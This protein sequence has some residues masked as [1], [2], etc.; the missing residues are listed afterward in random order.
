MI[1]TVQ[2]TDDML[3]AE[4]AREI[5]DRIVVERKMKS[6][7]EIA[8][9]HGSGL[10]NYVQIMIQEYASEGLFQ[11]TYTVYEKDYFKY[12]HLITD[13]QY[14]GYQVKVNNISNPHHEM[15][16]YTISWKHDTASS[17]L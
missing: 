1:N 16:K 5:A 6:N 13:F 14:L 4:D 12:R 10:Y 7:E 3:K 8:K 15:K 17:T 9:R 2:T 11:F